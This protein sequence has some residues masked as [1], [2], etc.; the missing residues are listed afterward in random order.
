[1][2]GH[3]DKIADQVAEAIVDAYLEQ[4]PDS[5]L[6]CEVVT[7][8]GMIMVFGSVTSNAKIDS[9]R[10][11]RGT[12]KHIGYDSSEKGLDYKTME[13]LN[14]LEIRRRDASSR[15]S[16]NEPEL[17][18]EGL[19]VGYATNETPEVVPLTQQLA[20]KLCEVLGS[21]QTRRRFP[22]I[23]L[24]G[25]AQV[26][27]EYKKTQDGSLQAIRAHTVVVSVQHAPDANI[28]RLRT[29]LI[30]NVIKVVIP[31]NLLDADTQF[32]VNPTGRFV[33]GGPRGDAGVS[34][35]QGVADSGGGWIAHGGGSAMGKDGFKVQRC[36][37]Y[38]ARWVAKSLVQAGFAS[39]CSVQLAY[40]SGK[41]EPLSLSLDSFGSARSGLSD[42]DLCGIVNQHFN[43][44]PGVLVRELQLRKPQFYRYATYGHCGRTDPTPQWE[45]PK[46]LTGEAMQA[47]I[48]Q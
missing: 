7:K 21:V 24:D 5:I 18:A 22:W 48:W 27:L 23:R 46:S 25:K 43:L 4:D 33:I 13:V 42:E 15:E 35:R 47:N 2:Q 32:L 41:A 26:T 28:E 17:Q 44:R 16:L 8:T 12:V 37:T 9:D 14:R 19:F 10:V 20:S 29:D 38:A 40:G 31:A 36:G 6:S 34:G 45:K 39:R 1:M 11:I 3:P 30:K